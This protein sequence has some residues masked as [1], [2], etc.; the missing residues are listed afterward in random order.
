MSK[1]IC[2]DM[3][4]FNFRKLHV[5]KSQPLGR[6]SFGAVYKAKCD[7]LPCAAKVLHDHMLITQ[8]AQVDRIVEQFRRECEFLSNIR[9]PH[10]VQ[11]LGM[12]QIL[13]FKLPVLIM[14]LL[15]ESLTMM[16]EQSKQPL[17]YSLEV[18]L[19]HDVAL[20]IAYLHSN[21]I[22]HRDLSS[23]NV[24]L[25]A[26][27]KAKVTDFGMSK[28]IDATSSPALHTMCPG[29]LPY[30]PPE[31]LSEPP[32]YTVKL[33]CFSEGVLM[34]QVCSRQ[35][36]RQGERMRHMEQ[37]RS[38][39]P[40]LPIAKNCL[41]DNQHDRPSAEE[42]CTILAALKEKPD[43]TKS[44]LPTKVDPQYAQELLKRNNELRKEFVQKE[45]RLKEQQSYIA[46]LKQTKNY[47]LRQADEL[48]KQ[49]GSGSHFS[50]S[51]R[52]STKW[53]H[54]M[55]I[56][57]PMIRGDV[58]IDGN[59]AYFLN[60]DGTLY[61]YDANV[62]PQV[63]WNKLVRC[64]HEDSCLAVINGILTAIGGLENRGLGNSV[65][66]KLISL[67]GG[68]IKSWEK[69]FPDMPTNRYRAAAVTTSKHLIVI[70]GISKV[71]VASAL[72]AT[73]KV[74]V[75]NTA[76][77]PLAWSAVSPLSRPYCKISAA[78]C[79]GNI[80]VLGGDDRNPSK[81]VLSC[82]LSEL[83][84]SNNKV[85]KIWRKLTEVPNFYSTCAVYNDELLAI[86]GTAD[87]KT[88]KSE[89]YKYNPIDGTWKLFTNT[90]TP[91]YNSLVATFPDKR[92]MVVVGGYTNKT[93]DI[94]ELCHMT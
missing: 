66:N 58:A 43:Y 29:T 87:V 61:K 4:T 69:H 52:H 8:K 90:L 32:S 9:H 48:Q 30:M 31:A 51:R 50:L 13:E 6:G 47:L 3:H 19:C 15:E 22:I 64:P 88:P 85:T 78:I 77:Y 23:N 82:S 10:I 27:K 65:T 28:I 72:E 40:L 93:S 59:V 54:G 67:K 76:A 73:D 17:P 46:E 53:D 75:M 57:T 11:Y 60:K 68:E 79:G 24:L 25:T 92:L 81:L 21:D 49:Q 33:D 1:Q 34:V 42:L 74:E 86:G 36:P 84:T 12:K 83:I 62:D 56:S 14:E 41:Q 80:Y 35:T 5:D 7:Q 38:T 44:I 37:I 89:V 16:L 45:K 18:D 2:M 55:K 26:G 91:R 94:T 70:G 39:H 20:A 63:A 71:G